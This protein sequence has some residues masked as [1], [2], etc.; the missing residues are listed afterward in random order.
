MDK[1]P[2]WVTDV[3]YVNLTVFVTVSA[4]VRVV[5][6][7]NSCVRDFVSNAVRLMEGDSDGDGPIFVSVG[8]TVV[9][10]VGLGVEKWV[11][12]AVTKGDVVEVADNVA[13][14]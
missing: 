13:E 3:E 1:L 6:G 4:L 10:A 9:V 7:E 14:W 2:V 12:V 5:V 11:L 8:S